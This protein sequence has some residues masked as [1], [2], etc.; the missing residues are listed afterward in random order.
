M[1]TAAELETAVTASVSSGDAVRD[2][3]IAKAAILQAFHYAPATPANVLEEACIRTAGW[4]RDV[5]PGFASVSLDGDNVE[6]RPAHGSALRNSGA[7][8]LLSPWRVRRA[9]G[10]F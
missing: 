8:A 5:D 4:L 1:T 10:G 7:Q 6:Y 2:A 9:R 3:Q